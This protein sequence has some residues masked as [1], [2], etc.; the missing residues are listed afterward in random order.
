MRK[1]ILK[2]L[3]FVLVKIYGGLEKELGLFDTVFSCIM[4]F[5]F[6]FSRLE[7]Q[8]NY[9]N[10]CSS[11]VCFSSIIYILYSILFCSSIFIQVPCGCLLSKRKNSAVELS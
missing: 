11:K 5:I 9:V 10:F 1:K 7:N 4:E 2:V 6:F 8:N 3:L